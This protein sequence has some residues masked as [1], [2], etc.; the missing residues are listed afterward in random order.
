[1]IFSKPDETKAS[2]TQAEREAIVDLL[3]LCIYVDAHVAIKEGEFVDGIVKTIGWEPA[4]GFPHYNSRSIANAR[5]ARGN[6]QQW[7]GIISASTKRLVSKP[8][9]SLAVD[10]CQKLFRADG[11]VDERESTMLEVIRKALK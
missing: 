5:S 11:L 6:E 3:N 10:L 1:M 9:R 8:A 2:L 7:L 4:S